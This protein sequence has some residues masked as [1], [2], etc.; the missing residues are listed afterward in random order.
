MTGCTACEPQPA[1]TGELVQLFLWS[2]TQVCTEKL[3]RVA[4][5]CGINSVDLEN[6]SFVWE[7]RTVQLENV[8]NASGAALLPEERNETRAL[9]M[10]S[11]VQPGLT[12]FRR[13]LLLDQMIG[14]QQAR[15]LTDLLAEE[16]LATYFQPMIDS[17][18]PDQIVAYECLLRG[19][20]KDGDLIYPG[21]LFS[22]AKQGG[23]LFQLD[24]AA[25][26]KAVQSIAE[27]K[28]EKLA[29][30]NFTPTAIYDPA[31]CLRSTVAAV[32][33]LGLNPERI[34]F[35][36]IET[37]HAEES[38]LRSILAVYRSAG[39]KVAID[40]F[41]AGYSSMNLIVALRPDYLKLD[42]GLIRGIDKDSYKSELA[43]SL[44][45][46]A[47]NLSIKTIAE[48]VET[49]EEWEWVRDHGADLVQGYYFAKPGN[50]P[51]TLL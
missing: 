13:V 46:T 27:H 48:G 7:I 25:R 8:L 30:I 42:M 1:L 28:V 19:I 6:Q 17:R 39:F 3:L 9:L 41:G 2:P 5:D 35:E 20:S 12:D 33:K 15:W 26:R 45:D 36:I 18:A 21:Q 43:S 50:P 38:L 32:E 31:T 47:R 4:S 10:P 11:G 22:S 34:V 14:A 51:P 24:L 29:F 49:K 23:L 44:L 40:D 37:E 16:R